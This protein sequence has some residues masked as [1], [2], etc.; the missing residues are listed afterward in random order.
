MQDAPQAVCSIPY[1]SVAFFPSLK[2]NLIAYRSSKMSDW[3]FESHQLWQ[4]GFSWVYSNCC[5]SCSFEREIIKIGQ[6]SHKMYSN[7]IVNCQEFMTILNAHTKKGWKLI[8]YTS[9]SCVCV[10]ICLSVKDT[11]SCLLFFKKHL[12]LICQRVAVREFIFVSFFF[13]SPI[14]VT[15]LSPP[16]PSGRGQW[17]L[18]SHLSYDFNAHLHRGV[19]KRSNAWEDPCSH[20]MH[21]SE[22][23]LALPPTAISH[24]LTLFV[25]KLLF[26]TINYLLTY[27]SLSVYLSINISLFPSLLHTLI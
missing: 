22:N 7:N 5:C 16:N 9:Y 17:M 8:V 26:E 24:S 3:I 15:F 13:H 1:V 27:L 4:S 25:R 11:S 23:S 20:G 2:Q 12:Y 21:V 6:S 14:S 10:C 19:K 18:L